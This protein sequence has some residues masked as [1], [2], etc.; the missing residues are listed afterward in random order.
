MTVYGSS[1]WVK[2][3]PKSRVP[4]YPKHRGADAADVVIIGGGLTGCATAFAFAAA[5]VKVTLLEAAQI[6]QGSSGSSSGWVNEDPGVGYAD[7]ERAIGGRGAK[8]AFQSSV[9]ATTCTAPCRC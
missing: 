1:P 5:G 4:A 6:G 3:F 9:T 7:L 2:A 8:R